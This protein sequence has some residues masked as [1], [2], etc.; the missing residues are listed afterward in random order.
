MLEQNYVYG[1]DSDFLCSF[2]H[3]ME[4][5]FTVSGLSFF[6]VNDKKRG[7]KN[8]IK[9]R[10]KTRSL[11][12]LQAQKRCNSS[13]L[14]ALIRVE[15]GPDFLHHS[16]LR[17]LHLHIKHQPQQT[18]VP[19]ICLMVGDNNRTEYTLMLKNMPTRNTKKVMDST[20]KSF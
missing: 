3:M 15:I 14:E 11:Q 8:N 1:F 20:S 12:F 6:S 19:N 5:K 9:A 7:R 13:L 2:C 16:A 18:A 10:I 4:V 17:H